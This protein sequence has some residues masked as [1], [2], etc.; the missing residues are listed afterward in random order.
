MALCS[1][2]SSSSSS[3]LSALISQIEDFGCC[4]TALQ[5]SIASSS[6][7]QELREER[8]RALQQRD[9]IKRAFLEERS[10]RGKNTDELS[11]S[12]SSNGSRRIKMARS[13]SRLLERLEKQFQELRRLLDVDVLDEVA[14]RERQLSRK[15]REEMYSSAYGMGVQQQGSSASRNGTNRDN[16]VVQTQQ[17]MQL[18]IMLSEADASTIEVEK[19]IARETRDHLLV[20][21]SDMDELQSCLQDLNHLVK[22]QQADLNQIESNVVNA[23][24]SI[25]V[26]IND[27]KAS[28]G[29]S[30]TETFKKGL[31]K[32]M[33]MWKFASWMPG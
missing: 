28:K 2:T 9:A 18:P 30:F 12:S 10:L 5:Q 27:I 22:D 21:E 17:Q 8:R 7:I 31:N 1:S 24:R 13:D 11:I 32:P 20:L 4:I 3:S 16:E 25:E 33:K 23:N 26:G 29:M 6:T 14:E 19:M 15:M